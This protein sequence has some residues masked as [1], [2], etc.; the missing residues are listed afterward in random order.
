MLAPAQLLPQ[1]SR[2]LLQ[3][4]EAQ[5]DKYLEAVAAALAAQMGA[6]LLLVDG[7]LL[8]SLASATF[9]KPPEAFLS[10]FSGGAGAAGPS[11]AANKLP[12]AWLALRDALFALD[13]PTGGGPGRCAGRGCMLG[14]AAAALLPPGAYKLSHGSLLRPGPP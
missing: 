6:A 9:G 10:A 4:E 7:M 8:A 3:T 2:V 1:V 12:I 5:P 11:R 14:T 13:T